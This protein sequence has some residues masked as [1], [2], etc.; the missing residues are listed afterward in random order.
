MLNP[1]FWGV[2]WWFGEISGRKIL[3]RQ[4]LYFTAPG[5][6]EIREENCPPP[7]ENQVLVKTLMSAISAGTELLFYRGQVP[8][9]MEIDSAIP[10]LRASLHYPLKYGY[11]C[12]GQIIDL[13]RG[14]DNAWLDRKVF[15]FHPHESFFTANA[16]DLIIIPLDIPVERAVFLP[17]METAINLAM[18]ARPLVG[19]FTGIF[20]LGIVGLLTSA[21]FAQFPLG[22]LVGMDLYPLRR[23]A[24]RDVGVQFVC[25]PLDQ[26]GIRHIFD[27]FQKRGMPDGLDVVCEV[28]GSPPALDQAIQLTGYAGRVIIGSWY[29]SKTTQMNL[30]GAFHRSRI[31]LISSQVSTIAPDLTG[32]WTK[33]RRFQA[34]WQQLNRI[35][36]EKWISK[37]WSITR[38]GKAFEML[39]SEPGNALQVV[40]DYSQD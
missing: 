16:E 15:C 10:A 5:T 3:K 29:G 6:V 4:A 22:G 1:L 27:E 28:S 12:V 32:R 18:D 23:K 26:N 25:D 24:A 19:E 38:A 13:G 34:V 8:G 9:E 35:C 40:F 37:K 14:V 36:P 17:N 2:I 30:G 11:A 39:A 21:L 31:K 33:S 20:G 7:G